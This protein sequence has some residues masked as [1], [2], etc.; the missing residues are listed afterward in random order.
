MR[1]YPSAWLANYS[2]SSKMSCGAEYAQLPSEMEWRNMQNR[3]WAEMS[4]AINDI[5]FKELAPQNSFDYIPKGE[6]VFAETK[7]D[8]QIDYFALKSKMGSLKRKADTVLDDIGKEE[9]CTRITFK[10]GADQMEGAIPWEPKTKRSLVTV[11]IKRKRS[12]DDDETLADNTPKRAF[13]EKF[14]QKRCRDW[15]DTEDSP[16]RVFMIN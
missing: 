15:S 5:H 9:E 1:R 11:V 3:W 10:R 13:V 8:G 2:S 7:G 4:S 6:R 12:R 16:K 14:S